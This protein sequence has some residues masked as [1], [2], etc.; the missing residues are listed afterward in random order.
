M[1]KSAD[2]S[3]VCVEYVCLLCVSGDGCLCVC[4]DGLMSFCFVSVPIIE[5]AYEIPKFGRVC[6]VCDAFE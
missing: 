4:E 1:W 2:V 3:V 5:A 6:V